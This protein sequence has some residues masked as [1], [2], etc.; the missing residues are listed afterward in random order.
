MKCPT[1][2][3]WS[4]VL[5]T[6]GV[7]RRRECANGHRFSTIEVPPGVVNK[8]DYRAFRRGAALRTR[9]W[10]R[11]QRICADPR[12][13]TT[14]ARELGISEARVRQIRATARKETTP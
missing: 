9:N 11:D 10:A 4:S 8:K 5:E 3:A 1:C 14:I 2:G 12:G 13:S 6:R 7:T